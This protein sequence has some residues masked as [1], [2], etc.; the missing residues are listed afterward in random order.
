M[1]SGGLGLAFDSRNRPVDSQPPLS[2]CTSR[3]AETK[4]RCAVKYE[5]KFFGG[6]RE[7][8]RSGVVEAGRIRLIIEPGEGPVRSAFFMNMTYNGDLTTLWDI[9]VARDVHAK[10]GLAIAEHD[11]Q[12]NT[13]VP[14]TDGNGMEAIVPP[15]TDVVPVADIHREVNHVMA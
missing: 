6:V 15:D 2:A 12:T 14:V 7:P 9:D 1:S 8:V 4:G 10:L 5:Q 11:R 3:A 13:E